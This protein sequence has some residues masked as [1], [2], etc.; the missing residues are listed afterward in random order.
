VYSSIR[1]EGV[2]VPFA[3]LESS[4]VYLAGI[5]LVTIGLYGDVYSDERKS[6]GGRVAPGPKTTFFDGRMIWPS[7]DS[8]LILSMLASV[9]GAVASQALW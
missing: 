6:V 9:H 7:K 5:V 2:G 1:R 3:L 8:V 4:G